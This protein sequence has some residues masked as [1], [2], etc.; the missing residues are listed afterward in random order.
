MN[1]VYAKKSSESDDFGSALMRLP[2]ALT[3]GPLYP[4]NLADPSRDSGRG[5]MIAYAYMFLCSASP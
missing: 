3:Q 1:E 2:E 5:N 4:A